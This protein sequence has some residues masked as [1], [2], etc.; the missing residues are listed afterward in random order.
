MGIISLF[1]SFAIGM[2][3][4]LSIK[5][6]RDIKNKF[7]IEDNDDEESDEVEDANELL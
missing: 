7:E 5:I 4:Y 1:I 3:A 2:L 6:H